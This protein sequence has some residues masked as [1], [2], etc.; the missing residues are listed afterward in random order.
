MTY[1]HSDT[2][3]LKFEVKDFDSCMEVSTT[4]TELLLV[5]D[6]MKMECRLSQFVVDTLKTHFK[7]SP[8]VM[9]KGW[10]GLLFYGFPGCGKTRVLREILE[11]TLDPNRK[12]NF[13]LTK[14]WAAVA[15][16]FHGTTAAN[17]ND[18][19]LHDLDGYLPMWTR[20]FFAYCE[21]GFDMDFNGFNKLQ[22]RVLAVHNEVGAAKFAVRNLLDAI[23]V[24][25]GRTKLAILVD[26]SLNLHA[27]FVGAGVT[28]ENGYSS[29]LHFLNEL[30][31]TSETKNMCRVVF[32][33]LYDGPWVATDSLSTSGRTLQAVFLEPVP[34]EIGVLWINVVD[35]D[36]L[37]AQGLQKLANLKGCDISGIADFLTR[38][39]AGMLRG[40]EEV[41]ILLRKFA[42]SSKFIMVCISVSIIVQVNWGTRCQCF[43]LT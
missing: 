16:S 19:T 8:G 5:I 41:R 27:E 6:D 37:V 18:V 2:R 25:W 31:S 4:V 32:T 42:K 12:Y 28:L 29:F 10:P 15:V 13:E 33:G 14:E 9:T 30:Q 40:I 17:S 11:A 20:L 38:S 1:T 35:K 22:K 43:L 26:E 24:K 21:H 23:R 3:L 39:T 34:P 36:D 7:P